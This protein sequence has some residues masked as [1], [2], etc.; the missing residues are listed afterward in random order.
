MAFKYIRARLES[1][2]YKYKKSHMII[3]VTSSG[4]GEGKSLI[5]A[6]TAVCLSQLNRRVLLIDADLRRPSQNGYF[7]VNPPYGLVDLLGMTKTL[8]E[9]LTR[10]L[11]PNLDYLAAGYCTANSTEI[12]SSETFKALLN[13]LKN[14]YDYIIV[15]C[16]PVFA[17]VDASIIGSYSDIPVLLANFRETK[18]VH[19]N[20]AYN[21]LLQVSYKRVFGIINKAVVSTARFHYYGYHNNA[22]TDDSLAPISSTPVE[23][24]DIE[25]F[26]ENI[27][28]KTS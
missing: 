14:Q 11:Y 22:K 10:D 4:V 23:A 27:K 12:I 28:R 13:Y 2:R 6:N 8:D 24:K 17:A 25:K 21:Q 18:K 26:L 9:V 19:L 20:E 15:D 16:P 7:D 1:Y 3:S 5:S